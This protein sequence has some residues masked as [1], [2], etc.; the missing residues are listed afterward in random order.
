MG[1]NMGSAGRMLALTDRWGGTFDLR[2][3][4]MFQYVVIFTEA[5]KWSSQKSLCFRNNEGRGG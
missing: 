4:L 1:E 3:Y 5:L 2:S